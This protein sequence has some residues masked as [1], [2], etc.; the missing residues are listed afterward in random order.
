MAAPEVLASK[1]RPETAAASVNGSSSSISDVEKCEA[2]TYMGL[3]RFT[4]KK[5]LFVLAP[6]ILF[7]A[8]SGLVVPAFTI[9]L[10]DIFTSVSKFSTNEITGEELEK[11][12]L[13]FIIGI[14]IAGGAAWALGWA[15]MSLWLAF[16]E[17]TAMR[18]REAVIKGILEK[19]MTWYDL[20]IVD[21]GVSGSMN[22]IVQ[23]N[24]CS[25]DS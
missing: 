25:D 20:K 21:N 12:V 9:L 24:R 17:N 19:D 3:F 6:A 23:Y 14:V 8:A 15:R 18:A 11:E 22:K 7:A 16:G 5:D 4:T 2:P 10:G 13:P 1:Q